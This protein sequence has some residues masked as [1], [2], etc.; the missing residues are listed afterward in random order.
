MFH[1][2]TL[3]YTPFILCQLQVK[4]YIYTV[5]ITNEIWVYNVLIIQHYPH[6]PCM[7]CMYVYLCFGWLVRDES[8]YSLLIKYTYIHTPKPFLLLLDKQT[9]TANTQHSTLEYTSVLPYWY[10]PHTH[11]SLYIFLHQGETGPHAAFLL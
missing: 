11:H 6:L 2:N 7:Y 9:P 3:H 10:T 5:Q 8:Y 1:Y 4:M